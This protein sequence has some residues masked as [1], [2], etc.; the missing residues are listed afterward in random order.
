VKYAKEN[1]I[2]D[3]KNLPGSAELFDR[4][5]PQY[6]FEYLGGRYLVPWYVTT[7]LMF[8]NKVLFEEAG[9]D[10]E[11]PPKTFDQYLEYAKKIDALPARADG[12]KVYGNYLW[13][14]Q[15]ASNGWYWM[16]ISPI[17]YNFN[18][19]KFGLFKE[20]GHLSFSINL[21]PKWLIS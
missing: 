3:L 2:L 5:A 8:Y 21:N 9:L 7:Q 4:I 20:T 16:L 13:N 19:A 12:S 10:P 17:Y 11:K 1:L 15:L 18:G 14:E 6:I